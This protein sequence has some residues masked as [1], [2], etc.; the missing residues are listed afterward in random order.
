MGQ[1]NSCSRILS[2]DLVEQWRKDVIAAIAA[3]EAIWDVVFAR[4][5][6]VG[7]SSQDF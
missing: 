7:M 3:L 2:Q 1:R 6:I 4:Q 5:D